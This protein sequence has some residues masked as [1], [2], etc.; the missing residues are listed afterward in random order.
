ML[1]ISNPLE[2]GAGYFSSLLAA[3]EDV[4][5]EVPEDTERLFKGWPL[6]V[7]ATKVQA[8][9]R[10][11]HVG[12]GFATKPL[13]SDDGP[14]VT[15]ANV[16]VLAW[17]DEAAPADGL[18]GRWLPGGIEKAATLASGQEYDDAGMAGTNANFGAENGLDTAERSI[19]SLF[20][21]RLEANSMEMHY[22]PG[23]AVLWN[24]RRIVHR[25]DA[26]TDGDGEKRLLLRMWIADR[27][28]MSL[29]N[30]RGR[31]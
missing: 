29:V 22:Q 3:F 10:S 18:L 14:H 20:G 15:R 31:L 9:H 2:G 25:R 21:E 12:G 4:L 19:L 8:Y 13:G 17:A 24:N 6:Y 30:P 16:P 26:F 1:S 11:F 23:E 5:L 28:G 7:D 27:E